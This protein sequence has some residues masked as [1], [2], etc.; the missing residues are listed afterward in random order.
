MQSQ[1]ESQGFLKKMF[2]FIALRVAVEMFELEYFGH[3][4]T[5]GNSGSR[6]RPFACYIRLSCCTKSR[7]STCVSSQLCATAVPRHGARRKTP[8]DA[9]AESRGEDMFSPKLDCFLFLAYGPFNLVLEVVGMH[10]AGGKRLVTG[11]RHRIYPSQ[12]WTSSFLPISWREGRLPSKS[13][14]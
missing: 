5:R 4:P 2:F 12:A 10:A 8:A 6:L 1:T 13:G 14:R 9:D 11:G 3:M 7:L